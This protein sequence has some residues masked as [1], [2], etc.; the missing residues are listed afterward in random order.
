MIP[1][2]VLLA[3]GITR[4]VKADGK[5]ANIDY[6][7]IGRD[8]FPTSQLNSALPPVQTDYI[9]PEKSHYR[10]DNLVREPF[11]ITEPT[12]QHFNLYEYT[13]ATLPSQVG[14]SVAI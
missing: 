5:K 8:S 6:Q 9:K 13:T 3:S 10:T 14:A 4:L 11:S 2:I 1:G 7:A 12:T